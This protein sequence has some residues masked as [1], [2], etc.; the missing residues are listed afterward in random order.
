[1]LKER[2]IKNEPN[3]ILL[4]ARSTRSLNADLSLLEISTSRECMKHSVPIL[5]TVCNAGDFIVSLS[6]G[7]VVFLYTELTELFTAAS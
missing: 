2:S 4:P 7:S 1:M 3:N 5:L 6:V